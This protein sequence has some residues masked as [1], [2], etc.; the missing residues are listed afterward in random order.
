RRLVRLLPPA[1]P[2]LPYTAPA[3][4]ARGKILAA[5]R[6]SAGKGVTITALQKKSGARSIHS[7]LNGMRDAGWIELT[8]EEGTTVIKRRFEDVIV[9]DDPSRKHWIAWKEENEA[10]KRTQKQLALL[11]FLI[12][13]PDGTLTVKQILRITG[14]SL[15]IV[16]TL[17]KKGTLAITHT[18]ITTA[19]K[20]FGTVAPNLNIVPNAAQTTAIKALVTAVDAKKFMP[21][22]LH[23]VTG[24]GK[25]Q[26]YIEAIRHTLRQGK[27]AI[28][29][30]P[31]ISLTSQIV[32]RFRG[33]FGDSV[34][35]M[36]SRMTDMERRETWRL[37]HEGKCSIV[38]GP[39]SAV[40]A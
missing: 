9:I 18:E 11:N 36:H 40:F 13:A 21:F 17:G 30:V 29:L 24:S 39:R 35:A 6:S 7:A 10:K 12:A 20:D 25:T 8:E 23:G 5:L 26:V 3:G 4:S 15:S 38:I 22:M 34:A 28:V 14:I 31:E 19:G 37:A 16:R 27:T 32:Q 1:N 2:L 33:H